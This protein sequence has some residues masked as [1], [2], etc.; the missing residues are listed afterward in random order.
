MKPLARGLLILCAGLGLA[1][2]ANQ[3]DSH[4][5]FV[6]DGDGSVRESRLPW[7]DGEQRILTN[8][9]GSCFGGDSHCPGATDEF[10]T[11]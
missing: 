4:A 10:A 11:D 2:N 1:A 5:P 3:A 9:W 7:L 8:G 6:H